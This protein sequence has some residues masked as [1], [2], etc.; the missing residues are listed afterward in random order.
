M[1]L[2]VPAQDFGRGFP[3]AP[4]FAL[5]LGGISS[6][7]I[8]EDAAI[9]KAIQDAILWGG[10]AERRPGLRSGPAL[11]CALLDLRQICRRPRC[12]IGHADRCGHELR[13]SNQPAGIERAITK[14]AQTHRTGP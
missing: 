11:L 9:E 5:E 2:I 14:C 8:L 13:R 10:A 4:R 7:I 1:H 12:G 3:S 6:M